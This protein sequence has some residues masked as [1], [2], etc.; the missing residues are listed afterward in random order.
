MKDE[1]LFFLAKDWALRLDNLKWILCRTRKRYAQ[2][3]WQPLSFMRCINDALFVCMQ[4]KG[5]TPTQE[6]QAKLGQM[7]ERFRDC[8]GQYRGGNVD[9]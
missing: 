3:V 9:G 8:L 7:L 2:V 5:V 6:A 1:V 4:Q